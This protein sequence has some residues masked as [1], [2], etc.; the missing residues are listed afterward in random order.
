MAMAPRGVSLMHY[1]DAKQQNGRGCRKWS[2]G[3]TT[4]LTQ[5]TFEK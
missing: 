5:V 3:A 2:T 1:T 4:R